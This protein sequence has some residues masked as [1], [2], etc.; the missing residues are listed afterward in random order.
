MIIKVLRSYKG[1]EYAFNEF[2]LL[3]FIRI[4][5]LNN[6]SHDPILFSKM[7]LQKEK[8]RQ[9]IERAQILVIGAHI[10]RQLWAKTMN[11]TNYLINMSPTRAYKWVHTLSK[12]LW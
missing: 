6:N 3:I 5:A 11:T 4:M 1:G 8:I 7:V 2:N 9:V 10:P 12:I